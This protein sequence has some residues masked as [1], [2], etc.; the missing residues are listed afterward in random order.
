MALFII[1]LNSIADYFVS[2]ITIK[3]HFISKNTRR[4]K[5]S[6]WKKIRR[7]EGQAMRTVDNKESKYF[8]PTAKFFG[9]YTEWHIDWGILLTTT[10]CLL[11]LQKFAEIHMEYIFHIRQIQRTIMVFKHPTRNIRESQC[12]KSSLSSH[13][14]HNDFSI[15]AFDS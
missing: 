6:D 15:L 13:I 2:K 4:Y 14:L 5:I 8:I 3:I 10:V 1:N 11:L 12:H 9:S 7:I